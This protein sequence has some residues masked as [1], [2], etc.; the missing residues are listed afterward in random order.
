MDRAVSLDLVCGNG[1]F[2][3]YLPAPRWV[4]RGASVTA[5]IV[6]TSAATNRVRIYLAGDKLY[7]KE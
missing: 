1:L 4:Y 2:P 7:E 3:N 5:T 6:D